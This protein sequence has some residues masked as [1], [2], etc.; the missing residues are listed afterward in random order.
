MY[1]NNNNNNNNE[2]YEI[3]RTMYIKRSLVIVR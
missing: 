2:S 1:N 3:I